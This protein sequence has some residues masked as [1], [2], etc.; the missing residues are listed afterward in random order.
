M[1][2]DSP[3]NNMSEETKF[4]PRCA[5]EGIKSDLKDYPNHLLICR[6]CQWLGKQV[7]LRIIETVI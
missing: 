3:E 6:N 2:E 7:G 5:L 1:T 4:C